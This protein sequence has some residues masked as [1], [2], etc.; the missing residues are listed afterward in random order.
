MKKLALY[1]CFNPRTHTGCDWYKPHQDRID[2]GFNPRTHTGCD[3]LLFRYGVLVL[4]S[5]HAPT[6]GATITL[7]DISPPF[8]VSIHAPT[9]GATALGEKRNSKGFS[10]NPRTHTGCDKVWI[11]MCAMDD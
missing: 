8:H 5:I 6:R 11:Y 10:F 1:K 4:V 9:R 3:D 2:R 7:F